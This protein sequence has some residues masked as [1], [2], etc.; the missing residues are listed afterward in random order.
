MYNPHFIYP[1]Y[2]RKVFELFLNILFYLCSD[3]LQITLKYYL[4]H[5]LIV[6]YACG[7]LL[8]NKLKYLVRLLHRLHKYQLVNQIRMFVGSGCGLIPRLHKYPWVD[9]IRMFVGSGSCLIHRLHKYQQYNQ[10]RMFVG[11]GSGLWLLIFRFFL[12]IF[13]F[14]WL[15]LVTI[16]QVSALFRFK[17]LGGIFVLL[18]VQS[19]IFCCVPLWRSICYF[20]VYV[21]YL[22]YSDVLLA[23]FDNEV[24]FVNFTNKECPTTNVL[25]FEDVVAVDASLNDP[26]VFSGRRCLVE[27]Y[28]IWRM[29][30]IDVVY[31]LFCFHRNVARKLHVLFLGCRVVFVEHRGICSCK[32]GFCF[33]LCCS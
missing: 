32:N 16:I 6:Q 17:H 25:R 15:L 7:Q 2:C 5:P 30:L 14:V 12:C 21:F 29:R 8:L 18:C 20:L 19:H 11:S 22:V 33:A 1:I 9:Q 4:V 31:F 13:S 28:P 26:P 10:I 23:V 24:L 27:L 3:F